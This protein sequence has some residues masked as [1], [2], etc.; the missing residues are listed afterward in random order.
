MRLAFRGTSA[1]FERWLSPD[2]PLELGRNTPELDARGNT[3][4]SRCQLK[5]RLSSGKVLLESCGANPTGIRR[6]GLTLWE[7]LIKGE[8]R[9]LGMGDSVALGCTGKG[10]LTCTGIVGELVSA[11]LTWLEIYGRYRGDVGEI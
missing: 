10:A 6:S 7:W 9:P 4:V 1:T 3:R 11:V 2:A 8:T 5:L